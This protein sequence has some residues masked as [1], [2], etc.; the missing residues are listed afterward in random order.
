MGYV[1][2]N[3]ADLMIGKLYAT[4]NDIDNVLIDMQNAINTQEGSIKVTRGV[5]RPN[6]SF[7]YYISF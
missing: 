1:F 3:D 2:I 5:I 6:K 4:V 7:T